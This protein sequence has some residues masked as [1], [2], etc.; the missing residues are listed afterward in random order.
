MNS[1][2]QLVLILTFQHTSAEPLVRNAEVLELK[3]LYPGLL[4]V[5]KSHMQWQFVNQPGRTGRAL[6]ERMLGNGTRMNLIGPHMFY[7]GV[8]EVGL[9]ICNNSS[10]IPAPLFLEVM[11]HYVMNHLP[12]LVI[13]N[14]PST[15]APPFSLMSNCL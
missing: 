6:N 12:F 2:P 9:T 4:R 1:Q 5:Y 10:K 14:V 15:T 7:S 8:S 3:L 13:A 11:A